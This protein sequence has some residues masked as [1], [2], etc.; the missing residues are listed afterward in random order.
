LTIQFKSIK[1][2]LVIMSS[3]PLAIIGAVLGLY[4]SGY[5]LGFMEF[6][7][8]VSLAGM[9]IKNAVV[10]VE[11][12]EQAQK[13]GE[14]L[15]ESIIKAGIARFRPIVLTAGTTIGGLIPLGLFGGPLWE[16]LAWAMVAG[17][18]LSTILTLYIIPVIYYI[19]FKKR[20]IA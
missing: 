16:G 20:Q 19:S 1:Q 12:V 18:A 5:S 14:P 7:G 10:W 9:V 15:K 4:I 2:S 13:A 3:V 8:V 17:L 11:F 6:L